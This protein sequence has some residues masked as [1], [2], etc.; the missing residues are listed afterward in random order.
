MEV[1]KLVAA[2]KKWMQIS[3]LQMQA[4]QCLPAVEVKPDYAKGAEVWGG[5]Q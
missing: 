5:M 3:L 2:L 1:S 4:L